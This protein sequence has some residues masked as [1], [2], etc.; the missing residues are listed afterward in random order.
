LRGAVNDTTTLAVSTGNNTE[1]PLF[2]VRLGTPYGG[3]PEN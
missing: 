1:V 3:I 2:A